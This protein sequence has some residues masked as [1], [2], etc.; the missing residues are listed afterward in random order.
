MTSLD[1]QETTAVST[2]ISRGTD[3]EALAHRFRPIFTRIAEGALER[4]RA[5]KLPYEQIQ[6]LK[7][8]GF[9]VVRV[10]REHGGAGAT[11]PELIQR[12]LLSTIS[13]GMTFRR[14]CQGKTA[15]PVGGPPRTSSYAEIV[16]ECDLFRQDGRP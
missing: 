9:G 16:I 12:F 14:N 5:R 15:E 6:W 7:E 8:A 13:S 10:P 3:Y 11:I 4:E 2:S 1:P